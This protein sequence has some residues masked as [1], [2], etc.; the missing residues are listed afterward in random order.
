MWC[1][2]RNSGLPA[3]W[4]NSRST[5]GATAPKYRSSFATLNCEIRGGFSLL[6]LPL[7]STQPWTS[8]CVVLNPKVECGHGHQGAAHATPGLAPAGSLQPE[9]HSLDAGWAEFLSPEV[10]LVIPPQP[11]VWPCIG[12]GGLGETSG[13]GSPTFCKFLCDRRTKMS[14]YGGD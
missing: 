13:Q 2:P 8:N 12:S 10:S 7:G 6:I 11:A 5:Y 9:S 3:L 14:L 1:W 4:T